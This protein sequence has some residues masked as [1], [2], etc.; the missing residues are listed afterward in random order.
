MI[1]LFI[2]STPFYDDLYLNSLDSESKATTIVTLTKIAQGTQS[3]S[4][5]LQ[6]TD[7]RAFETELVTKI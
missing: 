2:H 3:F 4:K 1:T 7:D 6:D 5:T